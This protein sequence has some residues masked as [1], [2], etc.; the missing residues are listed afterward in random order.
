M[1]R[2]PLILA[3]LATAAALPLAGRA[4]GQPAADAK[5][6]EI[7]RKIDDLYR[8]RTS[9][10]QFEMEIVTPDW[11]RTLVIKSWTRGLDR[12]LIRILEPKKEAGVGTLRIGTEMWNYLPNTDKVIKI[13]PSMMMSSWMG[14]D[15]TNDDLVKE[16][17]FV[18]DFTFRTIAPDDAQPGLAYVEC[19]PKPGVPVVWDRI[20]IA[21]READTLPVWQKY[22]DE[23]G[24]VAR[25]MSYSEVKTFGRRTVPSVMEMIPQTKEGYKTVLRYRDVSFD[26]PLDDSLFSLRTLQSVK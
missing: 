2:H 24:R 1:N 21:V 14:S 3:A 5:A 16:Y 17:T 23:K 7:V 6:L 10:G 8:S 4:F 11:R 15:F 20:V 22:F 9:F 25:L 13:P 12:M 19:R 26:L 18:D